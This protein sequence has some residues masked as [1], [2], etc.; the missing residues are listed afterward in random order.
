MANEPNIAAR[1]VRDYM[2]PRP[3]TVRPGDEI[4]HVVYELAQRDI[5]GVVVVDDDDA[6]VGIL[7]ERDCMRMAVAAGYHDQL[8]GTV[9]EYMTTPV[10]TV[11]ADDSIL[12]LA[13]LFTRSAFRRCPVV[14]DGR[15]IG[16]ICRR[17]VLKALTAG[18]WFDAAGQTDT[19]GGK[20]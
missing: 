17:D 8:G 7:T 1:R 13:D 19:S 4:M 2:T 18:A 9:A 20:R 12:D 11:T 6:V 5:S 15:L 16:L 10:H 3:F 14:E